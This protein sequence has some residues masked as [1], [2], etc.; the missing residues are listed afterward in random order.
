MAVDPTTVT[1]T[2][3]GDSTVTIEQDAVKAIESAPQPWPVVFLAVAFAAGLV[4]VG[5]LLVEAISYNDATAGLY[6]NTV[7]QWTG[8]GA[9]VGA[10]IAVPSPLSKK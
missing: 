2:T 4:A 10:A 7:I 1:A 3:A 5:Y 6:L 8:L 9:L